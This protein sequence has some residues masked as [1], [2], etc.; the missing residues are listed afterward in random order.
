M[1]V[2]KFSEALDTGNMEE[3]SVPD[4]D[5]SIELDEQ[6]IDDDEP[7]DMMTL[8]QYQD[9]AWCEALIKKWSY[10]AAASQ[11]KRESGSWKQLFLAAL[12]FCLSLFTFIPLQGVIYSFWPFSLD[13]YDD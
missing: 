9:E 7:D 10:P 6:M 8:D 12:P 2:D 13:V 11:K 3:S 4:N 5:D 1:V